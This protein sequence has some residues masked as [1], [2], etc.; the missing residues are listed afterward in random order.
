[1][2][3][4]D[5]CRVPRFAP[6]SWALT[7]IELLS[8]TWIDPAPNP[9]TNARAL[10]RIFDP[11]T[12]IHFLITHQRDPRPIAF[13]RDFLNSVMLRTRVVVSL[14]IETACGHQRTGHSLPPPTPPAASP[15]TF[16][17]S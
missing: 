7:G 5:Y 16:L 2:H 8:R 10:V 4:P 17:I 15:V 14:V 12:T 9:S 1:M 6:F 13:R 11:P 3:S